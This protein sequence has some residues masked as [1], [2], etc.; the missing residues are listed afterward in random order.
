MKDTYYISFYTK[1]DCD[2]GALRE[3][4][5]SKAPLLGEAMIKRADKRCE[6]LGCK[7]WGVFKFIRRVNLKD[8]E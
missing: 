5:I 2:G 3:I 7:S 4:M 1:E 6:E 8:D